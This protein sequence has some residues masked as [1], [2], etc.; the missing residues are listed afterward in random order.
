MSST[1]IM[2]QLDRRTFLKMM[3][4]TGVG[5]VA[6]GFTYKLMEFDNPTRNKAKP[7]YAFVVDLEKCDGCGSCST[8]CIDSH[9]L[10]KMRPPGWEGEDGPLQWITIYQMEGPLGEKFFMPV[11]CQNCQKAPCTDVC[12]VGAAYYSE[13]DVTMVDRERCIGCRMCLAACPYQVRTFNWKTPDPQGPPGW[14]VGDPPPTK[15]PFKVLNHRGEVMSDY[16]W[17]MDTRTKGHVEKCD[18]CLHAAYEGALPHCVS[19]CPPGALYYGDLR[20]DAVTNSQGETLPVLDTIEQRT[21]FRLKE[22]SGTETRVYYIG[23]SGVS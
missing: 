12:P 3:V 11:M 18:F 15:P 4:A 10:G 5:A 13:F 23:K 14:K 20:E 19:G 17:K 16:S 22:E 8:A 9:F 21:F 6:G 7:V 1:P 2:E